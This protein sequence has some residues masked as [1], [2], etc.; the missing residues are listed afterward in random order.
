LMWQLVPTLVR[1]MGQAFPE[2][3]RAEALI[4]ETLKLEEGRFKKTLDK[5]LKL[6]DDATSDLSSGGI[7]SGDTAFKLYDTYGFPLDLTEDAL[8]GKGMTVD[9]DG[10]NTAMEKQREDARKAWAG[11]GDAATEALWFKLRDELGATE[12]LGYETEAAEAQITALIIDDE[13]TENADVGTSVGVL[14][15]QTPFYALS[16]GQMGDKG[17]ILGSDGARITITDTLKKA[18]DLHLHLGAVEKGTFKVG[19]QVR[20]NVD[21]TQRSALRSN[22]SA[23]HLLHEA[24]RQHLGDHVTQKGSL[25]APDRL[26]FDISHPKPVDDSEM[27]KVVSDVN[28]QILSNAPVVTRLMDQETAIQAGAMAL[29]GEKYGDEVRVV[30]MGTENNGKDFY[31]TELCGGTHVNRTGDIGIFKVLSETAVAAGVRRIEAVTGNAARAYFDETEASLIKTAEVLK[32]KPSD[33]PERVKSL[34]DERRKMEQEISQ[35]RKQIATGGISSEQSE[36][37]VSGTKLIARLMDGIPAKDLKGLADEFKQKIGSGVVALIAV[38]DGKA[39]LVVAVTDDLTE[40][41]NA[42]ELVRAGSAKVGGKGGGGRPDMAQA[43]G[44][45]GDQAGAALDAIQQAMAV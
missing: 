45:D 10:F 15:N 40:T 29:F 14:V 22:H 23:T 32:S 13:T 9:N 26:R 41:F 4:T 19:D 1:E 34:I 25:V 3:V 35:L 6:L 8:R 24:L 18:G 33:V 30:S 12:F 38:N 42:V 31:S 21:G 37:L 39:S 5:G 36:I 11:S 28:A 17:E 43:G 2:L 7:L 16:G 44:P 27:Q 20:L